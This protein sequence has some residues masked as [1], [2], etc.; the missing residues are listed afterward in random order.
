MDRNHLRDVKPTEAP[1]KTESS[2][3]KEPKRG[4]GK[5]GKE[6]VIIKR[7]KVIMS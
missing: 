2:S 1:Y 6:K 5:R 7:E 4:A 3:G